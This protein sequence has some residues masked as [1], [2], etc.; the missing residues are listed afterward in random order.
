MIPKQRFITH[1]CADKPEEV[2]LRLYE[3]RRYRYE[4]DTDEGWV[5]AQMTYDFEWGTVYLGE[6]YTHIRYCPYCGQE[7]PAPVE[8][9]DN[10][11]K[12]NQDVDT[13]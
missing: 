12:G 8:G 5:L 4:F 3:K 1:R 7:L 6:E 10:Q 9:N 13:R 11:E 2:S